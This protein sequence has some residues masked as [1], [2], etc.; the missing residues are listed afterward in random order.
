MF[1]GEESRMWAA[2]TA[3]VL[4]AQ[5][6]LVPYKFPKMVNF[7]IVKIGIARS[8]AASR[9]YLN[10]CPVKVDSTWHSSLIL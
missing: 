8:R 6:P 2:V 5:R 9:P 1:Q 3:N 7:G 10:S 4:G